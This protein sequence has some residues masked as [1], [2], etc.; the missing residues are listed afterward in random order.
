L[1]GGVRIALVTEYYHP[2]SG[3]VTEHVHHLG[4]FLAARGHEV[5]I[6]T[7]HVDGAPRRPEVEFDGRLEVVR[8]GRGVA[9]SANG[10][11]ARVT[12]GFGLPR[13][14]RAVLADCDLV[15]VHSPLFPVLPYLALQAARKLGLPVVGTFHTH[16]APSLVSSAL[17]GFMQGYAA[18]LDRAIAVSPSAARSVRRF[19]KRPCVVVPNGVDCDAWSSAAAALAGPPTMASPTVAFLGRLDP[20][21][22]VEI[23]LDAFARLRARLPESR[24]LIIGDGPRR[25]SLEA[26]APDGVVFAGARAKVSE[27]AGLL[28]SAQVLAFTARIVSH[29]MALLEGLAAG[30]P[31]VAWD[32]EGVRELVTEGR[33]GYKVPLGS[34]EALADALHHVLCDEP[35]RRTMAEEARRQAQRFDWRTVG[36]RIESI[37]CETANAAVEKGKAA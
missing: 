10:S 12:V 17:G 37:Y 21:N 20:R 19:V 13:K 15:H 9:I 22:E 33:H 26:A 36:A 35:R 25:A 5:R 30:L 23:L 29:P 2:H 18:A 27:R 28:A 16:F 8:I 6:L 34:R 14:V 31:A 11:E 32:I 3:G 1:P 4:R 24:L 7:S